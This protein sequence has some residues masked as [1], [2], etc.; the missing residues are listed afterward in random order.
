MIIKTC[1]EKLEDESEGSS[2]STFKEL[3]VTAKKVVPKKE[4]QS[5]CKGITTEILNFWWQRQQTSNKES[6]EY[7]TAKAF[8]ICLLINHYCTDDYKVFIGVLLAL[9]LYGYN[10]LPQQTLY[11]SDDDD[12]RVDAVKKTI[13]KI[14]HCG[15]KVLHAFRRQFNDQF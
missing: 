1:F 7:L 13:T 12:L 2:W 14:L 10:I 8:S 6:L 11:W 4:K 15:T 9:L 3:V 5:K